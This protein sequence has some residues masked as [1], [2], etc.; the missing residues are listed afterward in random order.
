M[1]DNI[2]TITMEEAIARGY[3]DFVEEEGEQTVSFEN[4]TE[5][6]KEYYRTKKC[7]IVDLNTPKYYS[8][9]PEA[10]KDIIMDYVERQEE[11]V[12]EDEKL[13]NICK[14][15]DYSQLANEL[16]ENVKA[17]KFYEPIDILVTF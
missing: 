6:D 5:E 11:M 7:Y 9:K 8:I 13:C 1:E 3:T 15:H 16:N 2:E 4:L 10:I 12:D 14:E 17:H